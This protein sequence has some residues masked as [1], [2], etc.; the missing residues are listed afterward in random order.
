[1]AYER[2]GS[3]ARTGV[4]VAAGVLLWLVGGY[5]R[6]LWIDEFHSLYHARAPDLLSFFA[7]VRTDNHPPLSFLLVRWSTQVLGENP[8]VIRLPAM[9]A[10]V[11][12]LLVLVRLARRLPDAGARRLLPWLGVLSTFCFTIFCEARMYGWLALAVLGSVEAIL[13]GFDGRR[14]R[15]WL[16]L[17]VLLGLHS[18]Y[19]FLHYGLVLSALVACVAVF[20]R[21]RRAAARSLFAPALLGLLASVPWIAWGLVAQLQH[22]MPSGA[23]YGSFAYFVES[24]GHLF[25]MG[26]SYV[27]SWLTYGVALP[28]TVGVAVAALLGVGVLWRAHDGRDRLLALFLV[29]GAALAPMWAWLASLASERVSYNW[30]YV[31]GSTGPALALVAMGISVGSDRTRA[32]VRIL[33]VGTMLVVTGFVAFSPG[34]EDWRGAV[35]LILERAEPGDAVL[36]KPMWD[37]D[38]EHSPTGYDYY[39]PRLAGGNPFPTEIRTR[40]WRIALGYE[41]VWIIERRYY[42]KRV[43]TELRAAF[44][45]E[46]LM[47]V[48]SALTVHL[49]HDKVERGGG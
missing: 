31:A 9:V 30:R 23:N 48:G 29:G 35:R 4:V 33:V 13:A 12:Y 32:T 3:I 11:L 22:G 38:R 45:R 1:M 25:F 34:Q 47:D 36:L 16:A 6:S 21:P 18:H 37:Q 28:G 46:N 17:W 43:F 39:A 44:A 7:S 20:D 26:M 24:L 19:Y 40:D 8:L 41:R 42:P 10:G 49:F 14:S 27:G 15:W 5:S 2:P